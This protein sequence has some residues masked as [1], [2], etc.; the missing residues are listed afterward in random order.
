[1]AQFQVRNPTHLISCHLE[2]FNSSYNTLNGDRYGKAQ[3]VA[4]KHILSLLSLINYTFEVGSLYY[5]DTVESKSDGAKFLMASDTSQA[6]I[7]STLFSRAS[8]IWN[9]KIF[10]NSASINIFKKSKHVYWLLVYGG[11]WP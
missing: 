10:L 6:P 1:M 7:A 11:G 2:T 5:L 3:K 9:G 4:K 8:Q